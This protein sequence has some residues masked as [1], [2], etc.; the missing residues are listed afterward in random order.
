M[1]KIAKNIGKKRN[2]SFSIN[3]IKNGNINTNKKV[4]DL[5]KQIIKI[6]KEEITNL[7]LKLFV[8][9]IKY[10]LGIKID[11]RQSS[12]LKFSETQKLY[13]IKI[14]IMINTMK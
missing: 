6:I 14:G 10:K 3:I 8:I 5:T 4:D 2:L 7:Y 11:K 12:K 9:N 1:A 13:G